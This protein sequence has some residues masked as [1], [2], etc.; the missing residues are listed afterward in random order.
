MLIIRISLYV[1]LQNSSVIVIIDNG[2]TVVVVGVVVVAGSAFAIILQ[3]L[4]CQQETP[5]IVGDSWY[6]ELRS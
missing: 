3:S 1:I 6:S 2:G 4:V 5:A